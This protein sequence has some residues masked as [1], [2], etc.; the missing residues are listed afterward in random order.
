[1]P[2]LD[3]LR[4]YER[5]VL[6]LLGAVVA[7]RLL[8]LLRLLLAPLFVSLASLDRV[9]I[10]HIG[11]CLPSSLSSLARCTCSAAIP[12]FAAVPSTPGAKRDGSVGPNSRR[13]VSP[14][15]RASRPRRSRS[16]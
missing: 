10:G 6:V 5:V 11:K 14:A 7:A 9:V 16:R 3:L 2:G 15:G 1:G 4:I 13:P 12:T 8:R